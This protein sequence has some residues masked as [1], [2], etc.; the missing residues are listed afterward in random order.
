MVIDLANM[1]KF[2]VLNIGLN[3]NMVT[4]KCVCVCVC[5]CFNLLAVTSG[6]SE[7]GV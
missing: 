5:V 6:L 4:A 1:C 3:N 7:L 2:F